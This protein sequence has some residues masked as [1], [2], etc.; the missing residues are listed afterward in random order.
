MVV[1]RW[2]CSCLSGS[3]LPWPWQV[4]LVID[5]AVT[6]VEDLSSLEEYLAGLGKRH[7]AVGVK[8]SSFS[9]GKGA[10]PAPRPPL[11]QCSLSVCSFSP[12]PYLQ[13]TRA[14][15]LQLLLPCCVTP[16]TALTSLSLRF[17]FPGVAS[18]RTMES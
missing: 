14:G 18:L 17:F 11:S 7:R 15:G 2:D 3:L 1:S 16:G 9:V 13:M 8:L 12:F 5:T 10:L 4:M 6:N